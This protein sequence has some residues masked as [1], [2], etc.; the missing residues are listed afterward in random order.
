MRK[1][2]WCVRLKLSCRIE[3]IKIVVKKYSS[4]GVSTI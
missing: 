1:A 2:N 4:R 3:P